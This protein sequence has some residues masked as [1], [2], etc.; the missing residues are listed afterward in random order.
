MKR[1]KSHTNRLLK[2]ESSSTE[3]LCVLLLAQHA[4]QLGTPTA[5]GL[6]PNALRSDDLRRWSHVL[7]KELQQDVEVVCPLGV[8]RDVQDDHLVRGPY[9]QPAHF[10]TCQVQSS[11]YLVIVGEAGRAGC[12]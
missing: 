3:L 6:V 11:L 8:F 10:S 9:H 4:K 2:N 1:D 7:V 12:V 5:A